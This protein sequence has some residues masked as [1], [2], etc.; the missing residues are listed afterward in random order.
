MLGVSDI[1]SRLS[2]VCGINFR[3]SVK[4]PFRMG[5]LEEQDGALA[6]IINFLKEH[7]KLE[8]KKL[9]MHQRAPKLGWCP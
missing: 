8:P 5:I 4:F 2:C 6:K 1:V 9:L 7:L 3:W